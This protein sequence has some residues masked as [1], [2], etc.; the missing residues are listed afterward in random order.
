LE[1]DGAS[2]PKP[3]TT[4]QVN[5]EKTMTDQQSLLGVNPELP[6]NTIASI[7]QAGILARIS[8]DGIM[9]FTVEA[10]DENAAKFVASI[11]NVIKRRITGIDVDVRP[12]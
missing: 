11:E 4:I 10:N 2:E 1:E 7:H 9:R 3:E 5:K 6:E 8:D 12:A